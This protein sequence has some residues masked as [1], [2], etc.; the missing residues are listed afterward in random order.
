MITNRQ[1]ISDALMMLNVLAETEAASAEQGAQGLRVLNAMLAE[2]EQ[3]GVDL[4]YYAQSTLADECPIPASEEQTVTASLAVRLA[5]FYQG[6][7]PSIASGIANRGYDRLLR[8][9]I[10]DQMRAADMSHLPR[11]SAAVWNINTD[12]IV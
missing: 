9:A 4:G 5:A 7:D 6:A 1:L 11:G 10:V 12:T 2:W 8:T 3:H